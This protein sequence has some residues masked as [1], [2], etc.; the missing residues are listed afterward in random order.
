VANGKPA[1]SPNCGP[2]RIARLEAEIAGLKTELDRA[3]ELAQRQP[4]HQVD[5]RTLPRWLARLVTRYQR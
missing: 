5:I 1:W 4:P 2:A 3:R